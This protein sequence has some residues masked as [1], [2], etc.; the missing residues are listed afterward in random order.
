EMD[1]TSSFIPD[2]DRTY[3]AASPNHQY[4]YPPSGTQAFVVNY[5]NPDPAKNEALNNLDF[6]R[7]FSMALDRQTIID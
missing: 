7:A 2:I 5:K 4:W 6:R 3:A 1:W